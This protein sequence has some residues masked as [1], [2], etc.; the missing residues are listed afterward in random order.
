[1]QDDGVRQTLQVLQRRVNQQLCREIAVLV[2]ESRVAVIERTHA[3]IHRV[4]RGGELAGFRPIDEAQVGDSR[5]DLQVLNRFVRETEVDSR[6]VTARCQHPA[7]VLIINDFAPINRRAAATAASVVACKVIDDIHQTTVLH[8]RQVLEID[9]AR[10]LHVELSVDIPYFG[11]SVQVQRFGIRTEVQ[12][13]QEELELTTDRPLLVQTMTVTGTNLRVHHR[14]GT[15]TAEIEAV[16]AAVEVCHTAA[17]GEVEQTLRSGC[18]DIN[19]LVDANRQVSFILDA[20]T[21]VDEAQR[22]TG[23]T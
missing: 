21:H 7:Y 20:E 18:T 6:T 9:R 8:L 12:L 5:R 19:A 11:V 22:H 16:D 1:M 15:K 2:I 13:T 10:Q 4:H 17:Q 3:F 14:A 23:L